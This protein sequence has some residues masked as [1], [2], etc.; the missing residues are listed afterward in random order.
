V[1]FSDAAAVFGGVLVLSF[2][3]TLLLAGTFT[4]Y[5]GA[6]KSRK[7]GLG[8]V[9]V[10]LLTLF[11]WTTI[12]FGVRVFTTVQAWNADQMES[13]VAALVA[14]ALGVVVGL[15]LFLVAIMRA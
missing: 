11:A 8:L 5:F 14:G 4:G 15:A 3:L 10:G 6:G 1:P 13:G 12:T 7:I 2:G 9:L